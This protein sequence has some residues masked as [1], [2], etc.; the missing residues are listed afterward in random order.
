MSNNASLLSTINFNPITP[1]HEKEQPNYSQHSI[2]Q[3]NLNGNN[4]NNEFIEKLFGENYNFKLEISNLKNK[5]IQYKLEN[6]KLKSK[7]KKYV[8][9]SEF[10]EKKLETYKI[11]NG[12][13]NMYLFSNN[14]NF[15]NSSLK[16]QGDFERLYYE[17]C[18]EFENFEQN[19]D[20]ISEKFSSVLEKIQSYQYN[21]IEDNKRLKEF[22]IF[23][24]Q[25][26][27]HKQ[28]E[29]ISCIISYAK[30][31]QTFIDKQIFE[32]PGGDS[33]KLIEKNYFEKSGSTTINQDSNKNI[34]NSNVKKETIQQE[35]LTSEE[36]FNE[37]SNKNMNNIIKGSLDNVKSAL[38]L[39]IK[40][41]DLKFSKTVSSKIGVTNKNSSNNVNSASI[42]VNSGNNNANSLSNSRN[43]SPGPSQSNSNAKLQPQQ[44]QRD[45]SKDFSYSDLVNIY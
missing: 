36:S 9:Q 26:F 24:L 38:S 4:Y 21:L 11:S 23:I 10:L 41:D 30:E 45:R 22:L 42:D 37:G 25:C 40:Y 44:N 28:Y 8:Q 12:S 16:Q 7:L 3:S 29:H 14:M 33:F 13:S 15:S 19:F 39:D 17:K 18:E 43:K 6:D 31:H 35:Y 20:K 32:T 34:S 1:E 2:I 5:L 27:N